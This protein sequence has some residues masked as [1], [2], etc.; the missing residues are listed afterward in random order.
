MFGEI[1]SKLLTTNTHNNVRFEYKDSKD[2][3]TILR[4]VAVFIKFN[5]TVLSY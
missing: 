4:S 2:N 3:S 1:T 5:S